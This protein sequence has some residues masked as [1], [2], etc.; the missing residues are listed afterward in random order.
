M[1]Q[2]TFNFEHAKS[3]ERVNFELI[4]N[5]I[6][7]PVEVNGVTLSFLLD[8]GVKETI[9]FNV[10]KIDS[11]EFNKARPLKIKGLNNENVEALR[12]EHNRLKIGGISSDDHTVYVV[13]GTS[14]SLSS[15]LGKEIHGILGY[16]FFKDFVVEVVY[17]GNFLKVYPK[18]TKKQRWKRMQQLPIEFHKSKPYVM[19][20]LNERPVTM[21][22]DTGMSDSLWMFDEDHNGIR[23]YGF[24]EDFLG[25]TLSGEIL[26]KRSKVHQFEL[27]NAQFNDVK[28][29][30]PASGNLPDAAHRKA[31]RAGS[32]GGEILKRFRVVFDYENEKVYFRKNKY[33]NDPFY[34]NNS[35]IVI[36]QDE[37]AV[38]ANNNNEFLQKLRDSN[39]ITLV[40]VS[41]LLS[42]EFIVDHVRSDSPADIA[43]IKKDDVILEING[44]KTY[45]YKLA[46]IN[47][48]FY[49]EEDKRVQLKL[50]RGTTVFERIIYLKSPLKKTL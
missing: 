38:A 20:H 11:I 18:N 19:A 21:L 44:V 35:G 3:R 5:L 14:S 43:G 36:R 12:S 33:L 45:R 4:N 10:A 24:Y 23:D 40:D 32:I 37:E 15:Y 7:V 29:S 16:H 13:F 50:K 39:I 1:G 6:V 42:P 26:G 25:V 2:S 27:V 48:V 46:T 30:Y 34:Y 28:I 47:K 41:Y 31:D 17:T 22:I 9:V 49:D 8:T